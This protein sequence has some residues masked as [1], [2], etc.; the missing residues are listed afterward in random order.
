VLEE[1]IDEVAGRDRDG[2]PADIL[3]TFG[4]VFSTQAIVFWTAAMLAAR[5]RLSPAT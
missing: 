3:A 5:M 2:S 1:G 4:E